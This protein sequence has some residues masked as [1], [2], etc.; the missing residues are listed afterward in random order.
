M[1]LGKNFWVSL[2]GGISDGEGGLEKN[3]GSLVVEGMGEV[4][5]FWKNFVLPHKIL[6]EKIRKI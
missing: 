2:I 5:D 3:S 4:C 6:K 1:R